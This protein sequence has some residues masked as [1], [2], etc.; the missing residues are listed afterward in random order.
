MSYKDLAAV[1]KILS[2]SNRLEILDLLSCEEKCA[3]DL[4]KHFQFSQPTLSYHMKFLVNFG[5]VKARK[6]GNKQMYSLD[7]EK[8]MEIIQKLNLIESSNQLCICQDM[9]TGVCEP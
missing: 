7:H 4:L 3:C 1:L 2:D 8:F 9:K 6:E 5:I